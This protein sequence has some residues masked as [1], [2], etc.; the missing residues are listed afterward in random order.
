MRTPVQ[1][2]D[3]HPGP[4]SRRAQLGV[5]QRVGVGVRPEA[6]DDRAEPDDDL[7]LVQ[8][9]VR[10]RQRGRRPV[11]DVADGEVGER[12]VVVRRAGGRRRRQ[13]HV[14]VPG[15]L[16]DVGIDTHHEVQAGDG[17]VEPV[18]IRY[19]QAGVAGERDERPHLALARRPDLVGQSDR[20]QLAEHLGQPAYPAV[21]A[22]GHETRAGTGTPAAGGR[23]REHRAARPVEVAGQ[24]VEHVDQPA[25]DGTVLDGG[26]TDPAVHGGPR[27]GGEVGGELRD[28][29]RRDAGVAGHDG[30]RERRD[31]RPHRLDPGH[32]LVQPARP[33]EVPREQ[34]VH[35]PQQ[36]IHVGTRADRHVPVGDPR[37]PAAPRIDDDELPAAGLERLEPARRV[38]HGPQAAVGR[39]RIGAEDQQEVGAVDVRY[40]DGQRVPEQVPARDVLGHLVQRRR[41]V[42]VA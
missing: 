22:P 32:V 8:R 20:G 4:G 37:C 10:K 7:A 28:G 9:A 29:L 11:R 2:V 19:R 27:R 15:R 26:G 40:R 6:G 41:G 16:V 3:R 38:R 13:D 17:G 14:G 34:L 5:E 24:H 35:H 12:E 1:V 39:V 42:H 36:Q 25:G 30:R 33:D 21:P 23:Q 31:E 18:G